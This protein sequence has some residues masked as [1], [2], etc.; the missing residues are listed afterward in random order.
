M[1]PRS[2]SG[3]DS[4]FFL[5]Q[6]LPAPKPRALALHSPLELLHVEPKLA[7]T[8]LAKAGPVTNNR[9]STSS[10]SLASMPSPEPMDSPAYSL[11]TCAQEDR[12]VGP[13]RTPQV[14]ALCTSSLS[15]EL[16]FFQTTPFPDLCPA[17]RPQQCHTPRADQRLLRGHN[18]DNDKEEKGQAVAH[19]TSK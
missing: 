1:A 3:P 13:L 6:E 12:R 8:C 4:C 17:S 19:T 16:L 5:S 10:K 15:P 14:E 9:M 2:P 18:Q 11:P 7:P